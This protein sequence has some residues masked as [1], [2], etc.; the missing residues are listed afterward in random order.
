MLLSVKVNYKTCNY[1]LVVST[2]NTATIITLIA[3]GIMLVDACPTSIIGTCCKVKNNGFKFSNMPLKSRVYNIT[4]FCGDCELT[5]EGYCD[6]DTDGGGWLVVQ[7]RQDGSVDFN[8]GWTDYEEGFGSL[9]GE[10]WYGLRPLHCLT[11]Q[12]QWQLRIDL[13]FTN[14][15]KSYLS[16][17]KFSVGPA[18][19]QYQLRISGFTGITT[20]PFDSGHSLD[21]MKFTTKD[22]DNDKD[23]NKNCAK[24]RDGGNAGGWWHNACTYIHANRQYKHQYTIY[25]NGKWHLLIFMEIKIKPTTC[26]ACQ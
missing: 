16:Y 19:S 26:N 20:D 23:E 7:R 5:A 3:L 4:N 22:R 24:D 9:T 10:F 1:W 12:G 17:S 18:N 21:G 6:A 13:T 2:M 15:T 25:L 14:G 11:N 8:R